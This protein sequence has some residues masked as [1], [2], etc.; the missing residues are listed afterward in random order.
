MDA[1]GF[2]VTLV[3]PPELFM[4]AG[5]KEVLNVDINMSSLKE[6]E[7]RDVA[8]DYC[9]EV[10][11]RGTIIKIL[12]QELSLFGISSLSD[13]FSSPLVYIY[14]GI[15]LLD[16]ESEPELSLIIELEDELRS[17]LHEACVSARIRTLH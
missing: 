3:L 13:Y 15:D 9:A 16:S 17:S 6:W 11:I 7:A 10:T 8:Q 5:D 1:M 14:E 12:S 4:W 2:V